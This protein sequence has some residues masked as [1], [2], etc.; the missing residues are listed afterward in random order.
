MLALAHVPPV[1]RG[2]PAGARRAATGGAILEV[3]R[4]ARPAT[5]TQASGPMPDTIVYRGKGNIYLNITNRCS[6]DCDFCFR[7]F[8]TDVFGSDLA[9]SAEPDARRAHARDRAGL[10]RRAGRRGGLRRHGR[11]HHA[12]RRRAGRHRMAHDQAAA[13]APRD[14]RPRPAP[15]PRRS[16]SW[17]SL[18]RVGL[19]AVTV[20]LNAADPQTYDLLCRPMFSKAFRE[21]ILFAQACV[22]GRHRHHPHGGRPARVRPR[23]L[24]R[25]CRGRRR[26]IQAA[27]PRA[28]AG[29]P[30]RLV[31]E[32][33]R[34]GTKGTRSR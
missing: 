7:S 22:A 32:V 21:V 13:L 5:S 11:A 3:E 10:H 12:P 29:A 8:T 14:Q 6:C 19:G 25:D 26:L 15:Q 33:R 27:R 17:P 28:A 31:T 24:P 34:A 9:L 30:R 1:Y 20:S 16:T 23:R 4:A 2:R 18:A